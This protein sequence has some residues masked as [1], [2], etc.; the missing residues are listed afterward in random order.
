M[1]IERTERRKKKEGRNQAQMSM[2]LFLR[3]I[4]HY[5]STKLNPGIEAE[6]E[7]GIKK[8]EKVYK[9]KLPWLNSMVF[10]SD[11]FIRKKAIWPLRDS[12]E[13]SKHCSRQ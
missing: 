13:I 7:E 8:K 10:Q 1:D 6:E 12:R 9:K 3:R 2:I 4:K 5:H 11:V